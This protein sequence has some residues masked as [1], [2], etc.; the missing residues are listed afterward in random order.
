MAALPVFIL[1]NQSSP[2]LRQRTFEGTRKLKIPIAVEQPHSEING[3]HIDKKIKKRHQNTDSR[4]QFG[5]R[6]AG[7]N[8]LQN[9]KMVEKRYRSYRKIAGEKFPAAVVQACK[10]RK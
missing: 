10:K 4:K 7:K 2:S 6:L 9:Q 3:H 5:H 8:M 1:R